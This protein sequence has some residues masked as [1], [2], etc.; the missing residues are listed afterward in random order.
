MGIA[1]NF[2]LFRHRLHVVQKLVTHSVDESMTNTYAKSS[3]AKLSTILKH[4][5]HKLDDYQR[6]FQRATSRPRR[7]ALALLGVG[8]SCL[9]LYEVETLKATV[10]IMKSRQNMLVRNLASVTNE[11]IKVARNVEKL[12]GAIQTITQTTET[13]RHVSILEASVLGITEEVHQFFQGLEFLLG[14]RVTLS[15]VDG[16]VVQTELNHLQ[17]AASKLGYQTVY[18]DHSQLYQLPSSFYMEANILHALVPIPLIPF[19]DGTVYQLFRYRSLPLLL[20]GHLVTFSSSTEFLA[21]S[22]DKSR[23]VEVTSEMLGGCLHVGKTFLC[24]FPSFTVTVE[25]S[26]C[27]KDIF[28]GHAE[29]ILESCEV[30]FHEPKFQFQRING[31]AFALFT[32]KTV[33]SITTCGP[34]VTQEELKHFVVRD[35]SPG[36]SVQVGSVTFIAEINP[37]IAVTT[38]VTILDEELF[39]TLN[40]TDFKLRVQRALA[41][42]KSIDFKTLKKEGEELQAT[43][44]WDISSGLSWGWK[45]AIIMTVLCACLLLVLFLLFRFRKYLKCCCTDPTK[46]RDGVRTAGWSRGAP[47]ERPRR[48]IRALVGHRPSSPTLS[49]VI[50]EGEVYLALSKRRDESPEEVYE[51]V[52]E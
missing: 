49:E 34:D 36:C 45:I 10:N 11:T 3:L 1:V 40:N 37:V 15:L 17:E 27:L 52:Y 29:G 32:N 35:V 44:P 22:E 43:L 23:F 20:H 46:P 47:R 4:S 8:L 16:A 30:T 14:G 2:T 51:S 42:W 48:R 7:Q 24:N 5:L 39:P 28:L 31:T 33:V 41:N 38:V 21:I 50:R 9:S 18:P 25:Y 19:Q 26:F 12:K 6:I 13:L